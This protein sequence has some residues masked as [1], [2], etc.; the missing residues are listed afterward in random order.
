MPKD[1]YAGPMNYARSSIANH[2]RGMSAAKARAEKASDEYMIAKQRRDEAREEFVR[3]YNQ[4][5][6]GTDLSPA[7]NWAEYEAL[8]ADSQRRFSA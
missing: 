1:P 7:A 5:V 2:E 8:V 4:A 6:V 3:L